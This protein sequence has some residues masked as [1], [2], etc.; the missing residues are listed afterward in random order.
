MRQNT[1]KALSRQEGYHRLKRKVFY[2]HE[3]KFHVHTEVEQQI[4]SECSRLITNIIIYYNTWLLSQLLK[5]FEQEGNQEQVDFIKNVSPIAW[6]HIN[7][8]GT[9]NFL[10]STGK[11]NLKAIIRKLN[12]NHLLKKKL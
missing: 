9:Y 1:Q 8:Y 6:R 4:W 10:S 7:I 2:A 5:K 11:L 3:G 12:M